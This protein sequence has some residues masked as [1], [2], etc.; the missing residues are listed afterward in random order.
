MYGDQADFNLLHLEVEDEIMWGDLISFEFLCTLPEKIG[1]FN[2]IVRMFM[3]MWKLVFKF[4]LWNNCADHL[5][6]NQIRSCYEDFLT[7]QVPLW[8][9]RVIHKRWTGDG[10]PSAFLYICQMSWYWMGKIT[11]LLGF[12][13]SS[14]S[15]SVLNLD[16]GLY[17]G[18]EG[19]LVGWMGDRKL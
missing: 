13:R 11:N 19:P 18:F 10:L 17:F 9:Y 2:L 15:S 1:G 3:Q 14:G 6:S 12:S 7:K 16:L 8:D 5:F 4:K